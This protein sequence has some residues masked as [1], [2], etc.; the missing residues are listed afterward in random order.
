LRLFDDH[1]R[2]AAI[3]AGID[4]RLTPENVRQEA[5]YLAANPAFEK[6]YGWAWLLGLA[7]EVHLWD[8]DPADRWGPALAPVERTVVDLVDSEL[9]SQER[10]FRVGTHGNSAFAL[11]CVLDYARTV[12]RDDL[13]AAAA[14]TARAFYDDDGDYPV[15]YEPLGW[16]F[17]SPA[18]VEADLIRRVYDDEEFRGWADRF[19][20]DVRT[21]PYD[22]IL[23][24]VTVPDPDEGVAL[25]LVGLNL[26]RAW[27]LAGLAET[28]D[29]HP[30][31]DAF[32]ASARDH[33][34]AGLSG[35]FTDD[36]AGSHWLSSFALYLL[37]RTEGWI[38]AE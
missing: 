16:D 1:P 8:G 14:G 30:Y 34:E 27:C 26:S 15:E 36:Y 17:L 11:S 28:L 38:A 2:E 25:H 33:A 21:A 12:G 9:L 13:A 37:T 29:G 31:A 32:A 23:D 19:F 35:A 10:P 5:E 24:P 18:L 3:V 7:A 6:P 22:R 20:P 4:D